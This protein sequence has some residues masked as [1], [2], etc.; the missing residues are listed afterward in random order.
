MCCCAARAVLLPVARTGGDLPL[1]LRWGGY[2]AGG[3]ARARWAARTARTPAAGSRA[4][5][6]RLVL[7]PALAVDRQGVRLGRGRGFYD[8]SLRCRDPRSSSRGGAHCR[9]GRRVAVGAATYP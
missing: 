6:G 3:L 5:A 2:R 7:V 4:G 9:T 8:R 1:P